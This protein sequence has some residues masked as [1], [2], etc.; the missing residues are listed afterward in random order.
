MEK[1]F[2]FKEAY[3]LLSDKEKEMVDELFKQLL[4]DIKN[5]FNG[6]PSPFT[7]ISAIKNADNEQDKID[8]TFFLIYLLLTRNNS[9]MSDGKTHL[10][11]VATCCG[12]IMEDPEIHYENYQYIAANSK[13]EAVKIY[14]EKNNCSYYYGR[15]IR[16][17]E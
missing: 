16:I 9:T 2:D 5:K 17:V 7:L 14:N 3:K 6:S 8:Y 11:E 12:G 4:N 10:Y 1:D 13:E 15:V